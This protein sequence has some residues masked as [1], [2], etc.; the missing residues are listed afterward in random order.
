MKPKP[1]HQFPT[2]AEARKAIEP[3][4]CYPIDTLPT[5]DLELYRKARK[6]AEHIETVIAP[7]REACTFR[8]PA[9]S[10]FRITCPE[11]PQVG[12]LNLWNANNLDEKFYTGKTRALHGTH[13]GVGDRMW[14][15]FP[16]LRPIP[17]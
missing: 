6:G 15:S 13:L 7:P 12:D 16:Y 14:S 2:D 1:Q 11:G 8:V 17:Y 4:V 5:P 9:G 3:V 10:F